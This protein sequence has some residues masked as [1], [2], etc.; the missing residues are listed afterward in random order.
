MALTFHKLFP[1]G[2]LGEHYNWN[3][4]HLCGPRHFIVFSGTYIINH[5]DSISERN[6]GVGHWRQHINSTVNRFFD[7]GLDNCSKLA[8]MPVYVCKSLHDDCHEGFY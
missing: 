5:T 7:E 4:V 6:K 1:S 8:S 3:K 2:E